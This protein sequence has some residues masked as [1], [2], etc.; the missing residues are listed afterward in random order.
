MGINNMPKPAERPETGA[1]QL[2]STS[3]NSATAAS[4]KIHLSK[5]YRLGDRAGPEFAKLCSVIVGSFRR[6][7]AVV[8]EPVDRLRDPL[9]KVRRVTN[10]NVGDP[11][12]LVEDEQAGRTHDAAAF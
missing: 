5:E 6:G 12:I 8:K 2:F 7:C 1:D 11:S 3:T 10:V 9:R 4:K